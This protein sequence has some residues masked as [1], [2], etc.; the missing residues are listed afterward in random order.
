MTVHE[1]KPP[2]QQYLQDAEDVARSE[3]LGPKLGRHV[4]PG[5]CRSAVEA[6][7]Q[8]HIRRVRLAGGARYEDVEEA[9]QK[10]QTLNLLAALALFDDNR[11]GADVLATLNNRVGKPAGDAFQ[12]LKKKA[13]H[14][15]DGDLLTLVDGA[16]SLVAGLTRVLA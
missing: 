16:R 14:P 10:A 11:R 12:L 13:H 4:V 8:S 9:I 3:G 5:L 1:V 7:L 2:A 15:E 6:T